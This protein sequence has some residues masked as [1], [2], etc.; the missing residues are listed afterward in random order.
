MLISPRI[1]LSE[2]GYTVVQVP[3]PDA[4][5]GD[6][7]RNLAE[8]QIELPQERE[9]ALVTYGLKPEDTTSLAPLFSSA[10]P[11]ACVHYCPAIEDGHGLV[12]EAT[13]GTVVP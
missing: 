2:E 9:W 12:H 3:Y 13:D 10:T 11:R 4:E 5:N 7:V 6:L 8:A 1:K